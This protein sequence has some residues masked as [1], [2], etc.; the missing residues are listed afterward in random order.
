MTATTQSPQVL[1]LMADTSYPSQEFHASVE[2]GGRTADRIRIAKSEDD[3]VDEVSSERGGVL[4]VDRLEEASHIGLQRN[5]AT[6]HM[7]LLGLKLR[8]ADS[9]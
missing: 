6:G 1:D 4:A 8:R 7:L 3:S 2:N 5:I 9:P